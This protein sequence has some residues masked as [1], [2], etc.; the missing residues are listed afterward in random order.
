MEVRH[1]VYIAAPLFSNAERYWNL[2]L[3]D[4]LTEN[5]ISVFLPQSQCSNIESWHIYDTCKNGIEQSRLVI[6]ILD[7][8]DA[9]SGVSWECGYANGIGIKTIGVRTDFRKCEL[10]NVNIMLHHSVDRLVSD[11]DGDDSRLFRDIRSA[12]REIF[13]EVDSTT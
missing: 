8:S 7:G 1:D 11:F 3:A 13:M 4:Y 9:D 10:S 12:I 6:A 2:K 5:G